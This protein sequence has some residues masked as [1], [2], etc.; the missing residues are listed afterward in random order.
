M[1]ERDLFGEIPKKLADPNGLVSLRLT[2]LEHGETD[3]AWLLS[4]GERGE[5]PKHAPKRLVK[6]GTGHLVDVF[7]MPRWLANEKGWL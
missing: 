3:A 2:A 4:K 1:T 6:R 7:T 5:K